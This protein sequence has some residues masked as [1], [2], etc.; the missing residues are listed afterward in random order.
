VFTS[1]LVKQTLIDLFGELSTVSH[2]IKVNKMG[3]ICNT[4]RRH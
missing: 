4:Y 3:G 1:A 2:K